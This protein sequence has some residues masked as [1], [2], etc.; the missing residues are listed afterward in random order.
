VLKTAQ[1]SYYLHARGSVVFRLYATSRKV[2]G[3]KPDKV[4]YFFQITKSFRPHSALRFIQ[5]LP[6]MNTRN[7]KIMFLGLERDRCKRL[8]TLPP[9]MS[10]LPIQCEI[11]NILQTYRNPWPVIGI[12]MYRYIYICIFMYRYILL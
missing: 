12:A 3:S 9:S 1:D 6:E 10:R 2:A 11:L 7:R 8:T 5:S 4:N